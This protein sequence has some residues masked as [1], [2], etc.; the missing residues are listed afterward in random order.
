MAR[1][2]A[3]AL[4]Y[5]YNQHK[6]PSRNWGAW[7]LVFV[8]SAWG[9]AALYPSAEKGWYGTRH[10]MGTGTPPAGAPVWWTNGRHGHVA[11]SAGGGYCWSNDVVT[12]GRI[13]KVAISRITRQWG[14]RYRGWTRDINGVVVLP[15]STPAPKPPPAEW[16][17]QASKAQIIEA[18]RSGI[19]AEIRAGLIGD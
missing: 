11:L 4:S 10:R 14:Q 1:T 12:Y 19:R 15:A 7:C 3:Q 17:E 13:H 6:S 9:V 5:A 2:V 16:D 18:I 8:R